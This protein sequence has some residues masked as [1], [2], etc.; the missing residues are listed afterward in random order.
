MP[1]R[2][3]TMNKP[4]NAL[5]AALQNY[6]SLLASEQ[7]KHGINDLYALEERIWEYAESIKND[8]PRCKLSH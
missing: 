2:N 4:A 7:E 5:V 8:F 1:F 6:G 3:F